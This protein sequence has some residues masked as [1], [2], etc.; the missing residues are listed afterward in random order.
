MSKVAG[1]TNYSE[2]EIQNTVSS[3]IQNL[4]ENLHFE[5]LDFSIYD[6]KLFGSRMFGNSKEN[7]DLDVKIKYTGTAREDDLFNAL[8]YKNT[9]LCIEDIEIDFYPEKLEVKVF[10]RR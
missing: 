1:L 4:K 7:S 8:N 10:P 2:I 6:I 9:R 3:H 5:D